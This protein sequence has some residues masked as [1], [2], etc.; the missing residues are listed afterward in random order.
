MIRNSLPEN[1]YGP[2][3]GI[4]EEIHAMK[5]RSKGESFKD[6]M[7]RVAGALQDDTSHFEEFR[8]ILYDTTSAPYAPLVL[9][10]RA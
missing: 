4:S 8:D 1:N 5:Y 3:I 7:T 9:L 6:A 2:T 10:L